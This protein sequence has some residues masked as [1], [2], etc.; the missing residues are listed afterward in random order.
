[1]LFANILF[2]FVCLFA[3]AYYICIVLKL[4]TGGKYKKNA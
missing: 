4:L 1:M 3:N 2:A